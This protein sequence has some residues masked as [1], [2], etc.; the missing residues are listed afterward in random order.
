ML[1]CKTYWGLKNYNHQK[2][3]LLKNIE[4]DTPKRS[5]EDVHRKRRRTL[6]KKYSLENGAGRHRVCGKFFEKTL[7]ISNGP[8]VTAFKNKSTVGSFNSKDS[9]GKSSPENK[10]PEESFPCME[11]HYVGKTTKR[12]YLDSSLSISKMYD[13]YCIS[14]EE[15]G[16]SAVSETVYRRIFCREYNMSFFK[17]KKDLC[18]LC[19]RYNLA[20]LEKKSEM[21]EEYSLHVIRKNECNEEKDKVR[22]ASS[23]NFL[24]ANFNLQSIL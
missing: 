22:S 11:S 20:N 1:I 23:E 4:A 6:S 19:S 18:S 24:S 9:R 3:F 17:P 5:I 14:C 15:K 7:N 12:L 13:L 2:D 8:I 16:V 21:E 10:T